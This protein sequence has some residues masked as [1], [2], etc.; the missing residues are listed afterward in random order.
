LSPHDTNPNTPDTT[1]VSQYNKM[2]YERAGTLSALKKDRTDLWYSTR[3]Q[4]DDDGDEIGAKV[5]VRTVDEQF[6][7]TVDRKK[8]HLIRESH[9]S[10][11]FSALARLFES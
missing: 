3:R 10:L 11:I 7:Q 8:S 5:E 4:S 1:E 6:A 2:K 9:V